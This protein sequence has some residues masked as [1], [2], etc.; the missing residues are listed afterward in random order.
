[1]RNKQLKRKRDIALD[2]EDEK[3]RRRAIRSKEN[4]M[5]RLEE[6]NEDRR[7][8]EREALEE[9]ER[10][11][12]QARREAEEERRKQE[13]EKRRLAAEEEERWQRGS[14]VRDRKLEERRL[15]QADK[16]KSPPN[17]LNNNG[18]KKHKTP[19]PQSTTPKVDNTDSD[20]SSSK[21]S[22]I[23]SLKQNRRD[24]AAVT[25]QLGF[26]DEPEPDK[27]VPEKK[28]L[29][30]LD[31]EIQKKQQQEQVK[32]VISKLPVEKDELF[33]YPIDWALIDNKKIIPE[34]MRPWVVKKIV[35]LL[36]EE[37]ADL[38][39]F[40]YRKLVEHKPA[41]EIVEGLQVILEEEAPTFV[42]KLWRMLI[43]NMLLAA[44]PPLTSPSH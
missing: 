19:S 29:T 22:F 10:R 11:K 30:S 25:K 5:R 40:I 6:R 31:P 15:Q 20:K 44:A 26:T 13:E 18:D 7:E 35:E 27:L 24:V 17:L 39:D 34:K 21:G 3:G 12:E 38:I 28:R 1:M 37:E 33:D 32:E 42:I 41:Q 14:P 43:L 16:W 36:G 4:R 8:E 9:E 2:D 23:V